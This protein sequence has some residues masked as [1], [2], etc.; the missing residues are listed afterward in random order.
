MPGLC[1]ERDRRAL[2]RLRDLKIERFP[3]LAAANWHQPLCFWDYI[4]RE[5]VP[6]CLENSNLH[7]GKRFIR[8]KAD[9]YQIDR[10]GF[11]TKE[12]QGRQRVE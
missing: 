7:F 5:H 4:L 12:K 9:I 8:A 10:H 11:F 3:R 1:G 2:F 6:H